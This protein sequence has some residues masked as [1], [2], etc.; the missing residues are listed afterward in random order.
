MNRISL[1]IAL[2]LS[3]VGQADAACPTGR[4]TCAAWCAKYRPGVADC[5]S[6]GAKSCAAKPKGGDAC[7]GDICNPNND[8]CRRLQE[9]EVNRIRGAK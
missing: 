7:V 3:I 1:L 4:I 5:L 9:K 2:T 6:G 8:S